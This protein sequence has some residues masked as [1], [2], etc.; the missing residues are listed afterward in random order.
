MATHRSPFSLAGATP[1]LRFGKIRNDPVSSSGRCFDQNHDRC[2]RG[3]LLREARSAVAASVERTSRPP[4]LYVQVAKSELSRPQ[5][6]T[7][8]PYRRLVAEYFP[9]MPSR[10]SETTQFL[11]QNTRFRGRAL[12]LNEN[13][14]RKFAHWCIRRALH[15][16][17]SA[18]ISPTE[19]D[20]AAGAVVKTLKPT[21]VLGPKVW[22]I[23]ASAAS[24]P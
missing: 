16:V 19:Q 15:H 21:S 8:R 22:V 13:F 1:W 7:D 2:R 24:R 14:A 5:A 18:G 11:L 3:A 17:H 23:G 9:T 20:S 6:R 10:W 4:F 12:N